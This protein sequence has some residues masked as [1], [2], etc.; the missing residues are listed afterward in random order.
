MTPPGQAPPAGGWGEPARAGWGDP[1]V[2]RPAVPYQAPVPPRARPQDPPYYAPPAYDDGQAAAQGFESFRPYP[3]AG[4]GAGPGGGAGR[5]PAGGQLPPGPPSQPF[6]GPPRQPPRR[7]DRDRSST[8]LT[9]WVILVLLLGG[10]AVAGL[11]IAHPFSHPS[12][13]QTAS[14]G[15][16][17][18]AAA[19]TGSAPASP[20]ASR[21]TSPAASPAASASSPGVTEQQAATN[22]AALLHQSV[23]DRAAINAAYHS[24]LDC[25]PQRASAPA[26][27]TAGA[28]SRQKLLASLSTMSGRA[29]LSPSMLSD[30]SQAWQASIDADLAF[31]QWANGELAACTPNDTSSAA[32][33]PTVTPDNNATTNKTAFVAQWNPLAAKYGL[34]KYQQDQL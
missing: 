26:V 11:L 13:R 32:Y 5:G 6:Q 4:P 9:L 28:N 23:S 17:P 21:A 20:A 31:A 16:K 27:F 29:A 1:T 22:V 24:V 18:T 33:Q 30:L 15:A 10:G 7:H 2:T 14:T 34:T 8:P 19:G 25:S 12:L 3:P